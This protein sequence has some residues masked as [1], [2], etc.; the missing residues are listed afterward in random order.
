MTIALPAF[1]PT[2]YPLEADALGS[3]HA[4]NAKGLT[5]G[6]NAYIN[7]KPDEDEDA[8]DV[9]PVLT[10]V[11]ALEADGFTTLSHVVTRSDHHIVFENDDT[12]VACEIEYNRSL[13]LHTYGKSHAAAQKVAD[14]LFEAHNFVPEPVVHTDDK[15]LIN[16]WNFNGP[17]YGPDC[18]HRRLLFQPWE[19]IKN[20]YNEETADDLSYV[21][22]HRPAQSSGV[23]VWTGP[24]GTG[25]TTAIRT[26]AREW[27]KFASVH[28]ISDTEVFLNEPKYLYT[29]CMHGGQTAHDYAVEALFDDNEVSS[30]K[31]ADER[32]PATLII[33]EDSGEL[34]TADAAKNS[35]QALSR[36]LNFTDGILG[37]GLNVYFL[38]TTNERFDDLHAALVRPGRAIPRGVSD[39]RNLDLNTAAHWLMDKGLDAAD[40]MEKAAADGKQ[41]ISLAELYAFKN[42]T[43][44]NADEPV[45]TPA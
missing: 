18:N 41:D 13:V 42:E 16:I 38:I 26:L 24:P 12:V 36:L 21:M 20:N 34:L 43:E 5:H 10:F 32:G 4:F 28:I 37:Q 8:P 30:A 17:P 3:N 2:Q 44:A 33:L 27:G 19:E 7:L 11:A 31:P 1:S 35:G 23:M 14:D 25:K 40:F 9:A 15:T 6:G 29:V 45:L 22:A 39:F